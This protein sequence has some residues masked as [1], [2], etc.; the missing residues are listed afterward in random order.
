MCKFFFLTGFSV[1]L[2]VAYLH[3]LGGHFYSLFPASAGVYSIGPSN[4][5]LKGKVRNDGTPCV[6]C[7]W[8]SPNIA[9]GCAWHRSFPV[10]SR[11]K[12]CLYRKGNLN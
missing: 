11:V 7:I 10:N 9:L 3:P 4:M 6:R 12:L 5:Q 1:K 8:G 2:W